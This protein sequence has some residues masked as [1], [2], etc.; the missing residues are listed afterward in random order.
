ME[1]VAAPERHERRSGGLFGHVHGPRR[2]R[3]EPRFDQ[4]LDLQQTLKI[5]LSAA[6]TDTR[7]LLLKPHSH[8]KSTYEQII[9][10]TTKIFSYPISGF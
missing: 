8:L 7:A 2:L 10:K 6:N 9:I 1:L 5:F 4:Q 3:G